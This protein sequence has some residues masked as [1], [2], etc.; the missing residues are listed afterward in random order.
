LY[1]SFSSSGSAQRE[2]FEIVE[3][4]CEARAGR[5]ISAPATLSEYPATSERRGEYVP[6]TTPNLADWGGIQAPNEEHLPAASRVRAHSLDARIRRHEKLLLENPLD[7]AED[8]AFSFK[9]WI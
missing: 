6:H 9:I 4:P 8:D 5:L 2:I 1:K 3:A 7:A